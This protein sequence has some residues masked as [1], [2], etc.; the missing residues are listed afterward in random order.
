[1]YL[2]TKLLQAARSWRGRPGGRRTTR[3]HAFSMDHLDHRQLLS[4]NFSGNVATD[5]PA[6]E[7]PG[8][9]VLNSTTTPN[10]QHPIIPP[11]LQPYISVSGFDI[12]EIRVSYDATT[13]TLS[14]GLNQPSANPSNPN[15]P[16]VIAGDADNNG[17]A[18]TVNPAVAAAA[19]GFTEFYGLGGPET[20]AAF[21]DLTGTGIPDIVAGFSPQAPPATPT[22]P[23]PVKEYQVALAIPN[24]SNPAGEPSFG[25][26]LPYFTGNVYLVQTPSHPSLEFNINHFSQLYAAM[27]G[28]SFTSTT[29]IGMGAFAGSPDDI[30]ISDAF[31]PDTLFSLSQATVTPGNPVPSPPVLI[32]P[33]EHRIVDTSH[34]DLIRATVF[35]TSGFQVGQINPATVTLDGAPALA[36]IYRKIPHYEFPAETFVFRA[37]QGK[38]PAGLTTATL[39]GQLDNGT[40]FE[41]QATVLNIPF[42]ARLFGRLKK[43]MGGGTIYNR[44]AQLE[45]RNPSIVDAAIG[46]TTPAVS[47]N[48]AARG[49]A[50]IPVDYTP[51]VHAVKAASTTSS[52]SARVEKARPVVSIHRDAAVRNALPT[53]VRYSMNAYMDHAAHARKA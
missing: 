23:A 15:G 7:Q 46:A 51:R 14:I 9:V 39:K 21:L 44:L 6:T 33:H 37:D 4:V 50:A 38:L 31:F 8:V 53:R 1:M 49:L 48:P 32:N 43:Y 42:S 12:S 11:N 47:A 26:P 17:T 25:T 22:N 29:Q 40:A 41:T 34:R 10:I 19:P 2:I 30:G 27:T 52:S 45:K 20:M 18:G 5:F 13:D 28:H 3:R 16:S 35:G 36:H 24:G